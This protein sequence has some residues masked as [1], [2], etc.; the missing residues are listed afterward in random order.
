MWETAGAHA[1]APPAPKMPAVRGETLVL[2]NKLV[3][4]KASFGLQVY[5]D[6]TAQ[7]LTE[8]AIRVGWRNFFSSVL[9][10]NQVGFAKGVK[11]SGVPREELFICGSVLSDG[12]RGFD[13]AYKLT[14][15]GC[16]ENLQAFAQGDISYV[17]MIML[18]YPGPDCDS[19]RGQWK[20]F[21]EMLAAGGT[22]SLAVSNFSPAQLDCIL[23]DKSATVP[24][25]NQLP[26][27]VGNY[28]LSAVA[29]NGQRGVIVQAWSPL[30]GGRIPGQARAACKEIG[31]KYGKSGA[32]VAL[33]WITQTGA[34]FTTQ[35]RSEG[36]FIEDLDIFD[37]QLTD[38]EVRKLNRLNLRA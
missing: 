24:T 19:I 3:F 22:R 7:D 5:D 1:E 17:D 18:D 4:P 2:N 26:Y 33:R 27:S 8:K 32:Q 25:V 30:G 21:E 38:E 6:F 23:A 11:A 28:D 37:F 36:H 14:K 15:R 13:A 9:A 35:T 29:E 31:A 12:A 10:R 16:E 34:T 20:A